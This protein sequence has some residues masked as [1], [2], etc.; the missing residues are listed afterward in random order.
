[1]LTNY[2][3][4]AWR[5]LIKNK[6]YS[7][8]NILGLAAGLT[9]ALL[10]SLWI[11]DELSYDK[12]FSNYSRIVRALENSDHAGNIST[13]RSIP[14]PLANEFRSKYGSDFKRVALA[15]WN[16]T[17]I[18]ANGDKKIGRNGMFAQPDLPAIFSLKMLNG[19]WHCIDDPSSI[20]LSQSTATALFGPATNP[21][22]KTIKFN[23]KTALRVSGVFEDFPYSSEFRDVHFLTAWSFYEADRNWVKQSATNWDNNSFQ[24]YAQLQDNSNITAVSAKVKGALEGHD[25]KDKPQVLLHPMAKWHLYGEFKDG[26]NTGG[27][28]QFIWMFGLIGLFVLLLACINFMNLSTARSER[29]A[30]EVGIR[31]AIGSARSQLITQFLCESIMIAFVALGLAILLTGLALPWFNELADKKIVLPW[32]NPLFWG[33]TLCFTAFTGLISGSYPALYL[34]SFSSI[35]V[36]KG[37]FK[38]GRFASIPRKALVVLQFTVSVSLIIGTIVVYS[39]IQYAKDRPIGYSRGGLI[40]IDMNTPDLYGHYAAM[41]DDLLRTGAVAGMAESSSPTTDVWSNQSSFDWRGKPPGMLPTFGVIRIT[42][43]FGRTIGWQFAQGRDYSRDFPSDSTGIIVNEAAVKYMG[44]ASPIGET[45]RYFDDPPGKNLRVIGVVKDL[46][47]ESPFEPVKPT[48]FL[49][50]YDD[51]NVILVKLDPKQSPHETLPKVEAVFRKYNPGSPFQ[52]KFEDSE[53]AAKFGAEERISSLAT[54]FAAFAIF[55]SCLGLFGLAAFTA[56]QRTKEIGVR[57]VLGASTLNLW[58]L[59]S[60]DFIALVTISFVIAIP[61]ACYAMNKWLENY[62][63]RTKISAWIIV[64]TAAG[65]LLITLAT[66]SFQ[67][68]RAALSNPVKSLRSE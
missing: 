45:I 28:I 58:G 49:L 23:N 48:V 53:Y 42:H 3:K 52:Y 22:N 37:T 15:S 46:I 21:V 30:R 18:L 60:K 25:R 51:A 57:K 47:M 29:R 14:I 54:F 55:I 16:M 38:L 61:L 65:A 2:F 40:T 10:I 11:N 20:V 64:A 68:I 13:F 4:V 67:T 41:R 35:K 24:L 44:L 8:I 62:T 59:L 5:N 66:V 43:D 56:E 39:Q 17:N 7:T 33:C 9:I 1:M 36:L 63:Y 32:T 34:S 31:K 50:N 27:S 6:V 12:G 26:K 19:N